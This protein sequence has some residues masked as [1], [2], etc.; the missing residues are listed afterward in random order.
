MKSILFFI[1]IWS[2]F[3]LSSAYSQA[4]G[5]QGKRFF[6]EIGGSFFPNL[7]FPTAQ[8]KGPRSF[9]FGAHTG[10][11]TFHDRYHLSFHYIIGRKATFKAAYNYQV[12]GLFDEITTES[13]TQNGIDYHDLFYQLHM[14]DINLGFN[15]YNKKRSSLAPLGFY[16]DLGLRLIFI[17]GV[18]RDQRV[19]YADNRADNN[20]DP[21]FLA[22]VPTNTFTFALGI[23]GIWG[24]RTVIADRVTLTFGIETTIFPQYLLL[25]APNPLTGGSFIQASGHTTRVIQNVQDRYLTNIHI[26]VGALIF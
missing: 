8:N 15:L 3:G 19:E 5:Y 12:A 22:P 18:L 13:I 14:H 20:P 21:D 2:F 16:W 26:G 24:Y 4:P 23:T 1:T 25:A 17:N 7:G 10:D 6:I 9:P 11:I